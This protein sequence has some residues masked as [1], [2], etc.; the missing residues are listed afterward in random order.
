MGQTRGLQVILSNAL[1]A[2]GPPWQSSAPKSVKASWAPQTQKGQVLRQPYPCT[3]S[4]LTRPEG[5]SP[6]DV[7]IMPWLV[8]LV[9]TQSPSRVDARDTFVE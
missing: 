5:P 7:G 9:H 3:L 2:W 8:D 6:P 1:T 4:L